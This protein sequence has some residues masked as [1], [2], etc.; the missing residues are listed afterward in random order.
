MSERILIIWLGPD[1]QQRICYEMVAGDMAE[2]SRIFADMVKAAIEKKHS[3]NLQ[4]LGPQSPV[5][6]RKEEG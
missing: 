4:N 1:G 6:E 2:A 3:R 5:D